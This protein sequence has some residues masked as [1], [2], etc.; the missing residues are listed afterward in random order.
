[1]KIDG[2]QGISDQMI[3]EALGRHLRIFSASP[4]NLKCKSAC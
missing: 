2:E 1:M 3:F 4:Y